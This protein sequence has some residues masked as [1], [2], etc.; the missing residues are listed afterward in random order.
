M[1]SGFDKPK[2]CILD[3]FDLCESQN[4]VFSGFP[5]FDNATTMHFTWFCGSVTTPKPCN[6][7]ELSRLLIMPN[8]CIFQSFCALIRP[9]PCI[10]DD[11]VCLRKRKTGILHGFAGLRNPQ[12]LSFFIRLGVIPPFFPLLEQSRI[13]PNRF[14]PLG[15]PPCILQQSNHV[16]HQLSAVISHQ[17]L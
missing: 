7:P 13:V 16:S 4:H 5:R 11:S 8:P 12:T 3:G 17:Q 15:L 6:L 14:P 1:F 9:K 2:P 10:L